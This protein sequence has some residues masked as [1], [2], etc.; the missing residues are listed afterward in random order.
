MIFWTLLFLEFAFYM[1]SQA[2]L[3]SI[4]SIN[5]YVAKI[6]VLLLFGIHLSIFERRCSTLEINSEF[7]IMGWNIVLLWGNLYFF[8]ISP[9]FSIKK[10]TIRTDKKGRGVII[11]KGDLFECDEWNPAWYSKTKG[12]LEREG[13]PAIFWTYISKFGGILG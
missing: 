10:K 5:I 6:N 13:T 4:C 8:L 3:L 12:E 11:S 7:S 1:L 2:E 9:Y